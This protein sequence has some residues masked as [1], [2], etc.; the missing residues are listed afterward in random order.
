M[1]INLNFN[2]LFTNTTWLLR[3]LV[4]SGILPTLH[5]HRAPQYQITC[6]AINGYIIAL[7]MPVLNHS[8]IRF[9]EIIV[10]SRQI[11][12]YINYLVTALIIQPVCHHEVSVRQITKQ[13]RNIYQVN[14]NTWQT[15]PLKTN[16]LQLN[17]ISTHKLLKSSIENFR[18]HQ[19][20]QAGLAQDIQMLHMFKNSSNY[21]I[22]KTSYRKSSPP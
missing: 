1:L 9:G 10:A 12:M 19:F 14:I 4:S 15:I 16:L 8:N 5:I 20:M 7:P 13:C 18:E 22:R 6:F 21:E 11:S 2:N 3:Y 17:R